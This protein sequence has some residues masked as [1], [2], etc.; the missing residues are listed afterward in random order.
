MLLLREETS[1]MNS[2]KRK[3]QSYFGQMNLIA[4]RAINHLYEK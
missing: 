1:L 4:M 2:W 3:N